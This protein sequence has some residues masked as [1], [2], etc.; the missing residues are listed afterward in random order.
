MTQD[1]SSETQGGRR[2]VCDTMR[3]AYTHWTN[4]NLR[5]G[6][7]DKQGHVNNAV[8]CTLF[9]SGRVDFLFQAD[10]SNIV[11][12]DHNF[13]IARITL[14]YL[15]E[16]NFPGVAEIGSKIMAIGNSS[17]RIGQGIFMGDICYSTAESVIVLT[18]ERTRRST[19]LTEG[20]RDVLRSLSK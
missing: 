7:T 11:G 5:Y 1:K 10:G 4:V 3:G 17:F 19:P 20:L 15:V 12:P 13:V 14:D 18:D 8:Y 9:E 6:D 16:M 2:S